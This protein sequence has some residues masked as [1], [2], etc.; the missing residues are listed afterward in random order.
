V[1]VQADT[2]V[3]TRELGYGDIWPAARVLTEAFMEDPIWLVTGPQR[4]WHR[5]IVLSAFYVAELLIALRKSAIV[6]GAFRGNRLD[7]VIVVYPNGEQGFPWWTWPLRGAAFM[8]AGPVAALRSAKIASELEKML[9]DEPHAHFW[10]LGCRAGS[11]GV[12]HVLHR[13]ALK[14]VDQLNLP[15][16]AEATG[17]DLAQLRELLGWSVRDKYVMRNGK[18]VTTLW[19]DAVSS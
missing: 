7:G 6:L 12:G 15:S 3:E 2:K 13:A 11:L 17:P 4:R 18:H 19:R 8:L 16:Y 9:P 10:L 1:V 5:R 14:R